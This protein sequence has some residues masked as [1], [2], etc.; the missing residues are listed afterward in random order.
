MSLGGGRGVGGWGL[1]GPFL[2]RLPHLAFFK[3]G[4]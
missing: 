3:V 2:R 4:T 1:G